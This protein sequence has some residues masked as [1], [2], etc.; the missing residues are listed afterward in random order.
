MFGSPRRDPGPDVVW[1]SDA[2]RLAGI[3]RRAQNRATAGAVL[4]LAHFPETCDRLV[5]S[6]EAAAWASLEREG[7]LRAF[8]GAR[9]PDSIGVSLA[10]MLQPREP[11]AAGPPGTLQVMIAE[12][13]PL[14]ARDEA[15]VSAASTLGPAVEV[16]IHLALED[17]LF[18]D[19]D[20][21]LGALLERL[22][23]EPDQPIEHAMVTSAV[24]RAQAQIAAAASGDLPAASAE[25]WLRTNVPGR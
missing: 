14:R 16:E 11:G 17:A 3:A 21:R 5:A 13:H 24:A 19:L 22:G 7:D 18:A 8:I 12:R 23:L 20:A 4:V 2:A 6:A 15:V 25:E 1:P 9:Q 10:A